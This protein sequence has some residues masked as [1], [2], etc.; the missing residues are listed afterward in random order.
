M[1]ILKVFEFVSR[2]G[3]VD[4]VDPVQYAVRLLIPPGSYLLNRD[5]MKPHLG[6]L[7]QGS[8]SYHWSH[9]DPRMD[10]LHKA[11]SVLVERNSQAGVDPCETFYRIWE[12]AASL[13]GDAPPE[14][15]AFPGDRE[16]APRLTEPWFC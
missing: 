3:L 2:H 6:S 13:Q 15:C 8:F 9:P 16:R 1:I 10:E 7:D 11:V 14:R 12:L 4:H 5:S